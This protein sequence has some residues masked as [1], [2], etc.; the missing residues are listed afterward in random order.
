MP[1]LRASLEHLIRERIGSFG[2]LRY[3]FGVQ[4]YLMKLRLARVLDRCLGGNLAFG[5]PICV[6]DNPE[7][8]PTYTLLYPEEDVQIGDPEQDHFLKICQWVHSGGRIFRRNIFVC[9]VP[10]AIFYPKIGL[11]FD[12]DWRPVADSI[13]DEER[14]HDF[15]QFF[16]PRHTKKRAGTYS[17]IQHL[18]HFRNWHWMVDSMPQVLSLERYMQGRPLTLLMSS[19]VGPV[20]RESLQC[21][22]P[23]N[24]TVEYVDQNEWLEVDNFVLPSHV[25]SRCNGFLPSE[26]YEYIRSRTL[27]SLGIVPPAKPTGR[28]YLSR[29]AATHRRVLNEPALIELLKEFGFESVLL[30]KLTFRQQVELFSGAEAV[31]SPHSA[32]LG[33]IMYGDDDLKLCVFYPEAHPAPYF[34]SLACGLGQRHFYLTGINGENDHFAVDL[35]GLRRLVAEQMGLRPVETQAEATV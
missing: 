9:E 23:A 18:W 32:A 8:F 14:L 27:K 28:Y 15:K 10:T 33:S 31:V 20:E 2:A 17:S 24:F 3:K 5:K 1:S 30:E 19:D 16:R 25:S 21:I 4:S 12:K 7:L 29:A 35:A 11:L 34:H 26:Y 6:N 13:L 22:L